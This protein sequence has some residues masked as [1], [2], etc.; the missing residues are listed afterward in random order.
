MQQVRSVFGRNLRAFRESRGITQT[1]LS[2]ALGVS[3]PTENKWECRGVQPRR[4]IIDELMALYGLSEDDLLSDENGFYRRYH[5]LQQAPARSEAVTPSPSVAVPV[6]GAVH[7]ASP[8]EPWEFDGGDVMLMSELHAR[9]PRCFAL[10]VNGDCMDKVFTSA[11][12]VFID[13]AME[14]R[15]GSIAVVSL[16]GEC[17]VRRV[18]M[19][20]GSMLLVSESHAGYDDVFVGPGSDAK[21]LGCVFWWQSKGELC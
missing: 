6:L 20:N 21:C 8:D 2:E 5:G 16:G 12:V 17:V 19:G 10:E 18:K 4:R 7:A 15:D 14:P 1:Q 9:H 3:L 11:D 13:P